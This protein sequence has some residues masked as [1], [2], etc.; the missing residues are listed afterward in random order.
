M[1]RDPVGDRPRTEEG[2]DRQEDLI[3]NQ[4]K[5][6]AGGTEQNTYDICPDCPFVVN[7][8]LIVELIPVLFDSALNDWQL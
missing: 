7:G 1:D 4:R 6:N 3:R 2:D 5:R 8:K